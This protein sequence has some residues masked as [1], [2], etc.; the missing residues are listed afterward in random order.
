MQF[1]GTAPSDPSDLVT[2]EYAD[3]VGGAA[4][5]PGPPTA[6]VFVQETDPDVTNPEYS[7]PAVWYQLDGSGNVI[8][9]KLRSGVAVTSV[10]RSPWA[11]TEGS[12]GLTTLPRIDSGLWL[13]DYNGIETGEL[14]L[15]YVFP[16]VTRTIDTIDIP[17]GTAAG[18]TP[19]ISRIGIYS[20]DGSNNLTLIGSTPNDTALFTTAYVNKTKALSSPV[21]LTAGNVYAFAVLFVTTASRP[22]LRGRVI[23]N[24]AGQLAP[25][26]N[27][28]V[29][30]QTDLPATVDNWN[31]WSS[32]V[33]I[34]MRAYDA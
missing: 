27:G 32:E 17:V 7:G 31:V 21:T 26:L 13:Y 25:I 18:A 11:V 14:N 22:V 24:N 16:E 23:S 8:D 12:F 4:G 15:T 30:A 19:T 29:T 6:Q 33:A 34:Y 5:P 10:T 9:R 2:K 20:V 3:S 1:L 28:R